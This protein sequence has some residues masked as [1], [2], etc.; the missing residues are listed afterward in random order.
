MSWSFYFLQ[1][2]LLGYN[3]TIYNIVFGVIFYYRVPVKF[4]KLLRC[5]IMQVIGNT[6]RTIFMEIN[7]IPRKSL[8]LTAFLK[9]ASWFLTFEKLRVN[10]VEKMILLSILDALFRLSQWYLIVCS[11]RTRRLKCSVCSL[12]KRKLRDSRKKNIRVRKIVALAR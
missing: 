10:C 6:I 11:R 2:D 1:Y 5:L 4:Q 7:P 9:T 8:F 12:K 3:I